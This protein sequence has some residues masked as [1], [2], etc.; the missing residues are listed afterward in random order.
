MQLPSDLLSSHNEITRLYASLTVKDRCLLALERDNTFLREQLRLARARLFGRSSEK[1][2]PEESSHQTLLFQRDEE[3]FSLKEKDIVRTH[4]RR[5]K[6]E[7]KLP[8]GVRFPEHLP[9]EV[10]IID[11]GGP[12][13]RKIGCSVTQKLE[14]KVPLPFILLS[15]RVSSQGSTHGPTSPMSSRESPFIRQN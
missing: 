12:W 2:S 8:E 4:E 13:E 3:P 10:E 1:R 5:K 11:E 9:R 6:V 14:H 7:G 15:A